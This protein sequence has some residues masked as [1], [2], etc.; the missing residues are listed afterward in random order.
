MRCGARRGGSGGE[1]EE[2]ERTSSCL[3]RAS[4]LPW[5]LCW[6][7]SVDPSLGRDEHSHCTHGDHRGSEKGRHPTSAHRGTARA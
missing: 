3:T 4:T 5:A 2:E 6:G 7:L 1:E